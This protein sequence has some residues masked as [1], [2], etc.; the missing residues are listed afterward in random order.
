M[1]LLRSSYTALTWLSAPLISVYL[2][3]RSFK[4]KEDKARLLERK[5]FTNIPRPNTP[6]LWIHAVSVGESIV[7]LTLT[8]AIL[9]QYP[10]IRILLTTTTTSSAKIVEKRLPKNTIHQFCPAD[11][12]QAVHRFLEYWK[13]DLAIWIESEFWPNLMHGTQKRGIPTILLN[14]RISLKSFANWKKFKGMIS[15]LLS[16]LDLCA[17]QSEEQ[18]SFF[19]TLGANN[20]SV[21]GNAKV[22]M[23]P[24]YVDTK[25]YKVLKNLIG[26]RPFWLA[27]SS[28]L[29]EEDII[30]KAHKILKKDYPDLLTLLV[31]RHIERASSLRTLALKEG[32]K[33]VLRTEM[34]SLAGIDVCIGNTLG[35]LATFYALSPVVFMGATFVQKGGHNPIE[36]AQLGAFVLHGPHTFNNPQLYE[37]LSSLKLSER[38]QDE[39]Q[40]A[41]FI[42]PWLTKQ[43]VSYEEPLTLKVYREEN[44]SNLMH[45]LAPHLKTLRTEEA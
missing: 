14:G 24:L 17:V 12:P 44:L 3:W 25:E 21:M 33:P 41:H 32:L 15:A 20:I 13:P 1:S 31:P 39:D 28:H 22:M 16:R 30:F 42:R 18:A 38:V 5:G 2:G 34:T 9:K 11:T 4:G 7:A 40:L 19:Q 35:E 26:E 23:T 36:A 43:K 37:I 45:L 27:A 8:Q 29:G 10:H 6:L